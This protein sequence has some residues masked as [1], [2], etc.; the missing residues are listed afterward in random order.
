MTDKP[1]PLNINNNSTIPPQNEASHS[2]NT[3][4]HDS[5]PILCNSMVSETHPSKHKKQEQT[6]LKG[7]YILYILLLIFLL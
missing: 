1:H 7:K 5:K 2:F 4:K 6:A 3:P